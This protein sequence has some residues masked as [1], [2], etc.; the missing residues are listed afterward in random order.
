MILD[1]GDGASAL[2]AGLPLAGG[3]PMLAVG[4]FV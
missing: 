4:R 1:V 3:P 2:E